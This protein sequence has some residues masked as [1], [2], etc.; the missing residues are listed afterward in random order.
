PASCFDAGGVLAAFDPATPAE[1]FEGKDVGWISPAFGAKAPGP[2]VRLERRATL[3]ANFTAIFDL[4]GK[5]RALRFEAHPGQRAIDCFRDD[6]RGLSID[7]SGG[8]VR[9]RLL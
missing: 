8:S 1:L 9:R 6:G 5:T 4:S 2:V 3:P 7:W